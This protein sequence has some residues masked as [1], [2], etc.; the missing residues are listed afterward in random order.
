MTT[1]GGGALTQQLYKKLFDSLDADSSQV[2]SAEELAAGSEDFAKIVDRLDADRDGAVS[3]A[4]M[5]AAPALR[6]PFDTL[7]AVSG[8]SETQADRQADVAA[9]FERADID[10]DGELSTEE[11]DAEKAL[12]RAANLDAGHVSGPMFMARDA[13]GDGMLDPGEVTGL[14]ALKPVELKQVFYDEMSPEMQAAW[15]KAFPNEKVP[16]YT[17]QEKQERRDQ[18]AAEQAERA[19]GPQGA[20]KYLDREV[21]GLRDAAAAQFAA[22]PMTKVLS[23]RLLAQILGG[24]GAA[25]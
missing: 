17:P 23:S 21:G 24:L 4:E 1:I 15:R 8:P 22:S 6:L 10:G 9:L 25:A 19:S 14:G 11:M 2:L 7:R 12:R 5:S 18:L 13:N 3:R 20:F 16:T